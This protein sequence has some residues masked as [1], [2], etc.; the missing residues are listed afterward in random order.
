MMDGG[1]APETFGEVADGPVRDIRL[2][3]ADGTEAHVL[4]WGATLRDLRVRRPGGGL[5]S[6]VLGFD[7]FEP[8]RDNPAYMGVLAGRVANRISGGRF[9]LDGTTYRLAANEGT[10][11]L[12][13]GPSGFS[14]RLWT[15]AGLSDTAVT[16]ELVSPDGDQG[17]PGTLVARCRY[18]L[19]PGVFSVDLS[20]TCSRPCPVNLTQH[21]YFNLDGSPDIGEHELSIASDRYV[22][23]DAALLPTGGLAP[24]DG[25]AYD[26]RRAVRLDRA[27]R[28]DICYAVEGG[29]GRAV[30][31]F[32]SPRSGIAMEVATTKP[33]LQTYD[34]SLLSA[35]DPA[36]GRRFGRHAGL[37]L[38]T[39]FFPDSPSRPEF[40][41]TVLRPGQ[42]YRHR[43]EFRFSP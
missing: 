26:L 31:R 18:A 13:G 14:R 36:S 12:H 42:T 43:T 37:C 32:F 30:A 9:T 17:F 33:G 8:Y 3:L 19:S 29:R 5:Q 11:T 7:S 28:L 6:V 23:V 40:P 21:A 38:E 20:A 25:T 39:Q 27:P 2:S 10:T 34:G 16:L 24:V 4:T 41:D 22:P 15:V 1:P 35:A